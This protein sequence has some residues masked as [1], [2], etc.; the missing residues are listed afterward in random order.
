[1]IVGCTPFHDDDL[2]QVELFKKITKGQFEFPPDDILK[3]SA[4]VKDL[5]TQ[6]LTIVNSKRLGCLAGG[7]KDI[8]KH[9]Y[10]KD[11]DWID[12]KMKKIKAPWV[13]KIDDPFDASNFEDWSYIAR[14]GDED[15]EPLTPEEQKNF[16][17]V[18]KSAKGDAN[19]STSTESC[20]VM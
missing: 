13:P 6:M 18:S 5:I 15:E 20:V 3:M 17:W 1:M 10:F 4:D 11:M 12:L 7:D 9:P 2:E 19:S 8:R 16:G 14:E